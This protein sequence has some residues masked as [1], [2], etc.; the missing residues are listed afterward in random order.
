MPTTVD[1]CTA[2]WWLVHWSFMGW[3]FGTAETGLATCCVLHQVVV[4]VVAVS[5]SGSVGLRCEAGAPKRWGIPP[6]SRCPKIHLWCWCCHRN[7]A[8]I[9]LFTLGMIEVNV[10]PSSPHKPSVRAHLLRASIPRSCYLSHCMRHL[11]KY[12]LVKSLNVYEICP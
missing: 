1:R 4:V 7:D 5:L 2:I 12:L 11:D 3:L 6:D 8:D 9:L 10:Q